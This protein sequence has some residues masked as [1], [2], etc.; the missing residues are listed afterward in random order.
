MVTWTLCKSHRALVMGLY[1]ITDLEFALLD[2][3]YYTCDLLL[4]EEDGMTPS[5]PSR[6]LFEATL[7]DLVTKTFD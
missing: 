3:F 1:V 2:G 7:P 5:G 6:E 4:F